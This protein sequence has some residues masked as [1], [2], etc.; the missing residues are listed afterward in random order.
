MLVGF[1]RHLGK[2]VVKAEVGRFALLNPRRDLP[3]F[4]ES[5]TPTSLVHFTELL[6]VD[7][8]LISLFS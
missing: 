2:K 7:V 6:V 8:D 4:P 5:S 3:R 1:R